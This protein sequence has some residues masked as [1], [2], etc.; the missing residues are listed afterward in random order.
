MA[1][2]HLD[3]Q[4]TYLHER[5]GVRKNLGNPKIRDLTVGELLR[6]GY[7]CYWQNDLVNAE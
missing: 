4:R 2:N 5:P 7:E 6:R 3:A 1:I